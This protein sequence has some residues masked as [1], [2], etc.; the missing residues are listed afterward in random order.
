VGNAAG[1]TAQGVGNA[2][3]QAGQVIGQGAGQAGQ[4]AAQDPQGG[5]Q[6]AQPAARG[7]DGTD[8]AGGNK[9]KQAPLAEALALLKQAENSGSASR[10]G[11]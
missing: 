2:P 11:A 8:A 9:Q 6:N 4:A 10:A 1:Q 5:A 7:S 3:G